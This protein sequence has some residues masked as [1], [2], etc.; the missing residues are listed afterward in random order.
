M[1]CEILTYVYAHFFSN[2]DKYIGI[3]N[4]PEKRWDEGFNPKN[5][6]Q[7]NHKFLIDDNKFD[8]LSLIISKNLPRRIAETA[9]FKLIDLNHFNLNIKEE[10]E[11]NSHGK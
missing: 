5:T 3:S 1:D 2:G 4:N 11:P 8:R 6:K 10:K 9:E 7:Y